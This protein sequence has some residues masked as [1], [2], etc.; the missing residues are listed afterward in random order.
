ME[1][2]YFTAAGAITITTTTTTTHYYYYYYYYFYFIPF[3]RPLL[4]GTS[5]EPM[6]ICTAQASNFNRNT[7]H[8]LCVIF[9]VQLSVVFK[10]LNI[11]LA[12]LPCF[13]KPFVS[14]PRA[15]V[16]TGMV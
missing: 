9:L 13:F 12:W 3:H 5:H 4:P 10:L 14:V 11:F 16:I 7:F 15:P 2:L 6:V 8:I 1:L